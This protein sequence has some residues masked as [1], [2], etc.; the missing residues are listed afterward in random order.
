MSLWKLVKNNLLFYWRTNLGVLLAV[1]VSA[2][3]LT[4]ALVVGDSVKYSL[5]R[6]AKA[7]LGK[8]TF[9]LVPQNRF[10]RT[11]LADELAAKLNTTVAP[12]LQI[13]GIISNSDGTKRANK[14]E[15]LGVDRRFFKVGAEHDPFNDNWN[16]AV[17][18]NE[19]LASR[20]NVGPGDEI[21]LRIEKPSVMSRDIPLT[22]DSDMSIAFR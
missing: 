7:R 4:G 18:L 12:V 22:P 1:M 15:V 2:A 9:A 10:F 20:L 21:V 13:Q 6:M 8:T 16:P 5:Q 14:V 17:V 11:E 19:P 3:I